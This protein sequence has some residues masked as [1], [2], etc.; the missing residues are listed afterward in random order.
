MEPYEMEKIQEIYG[1]NSELP[2]PINSPIIPPHLIKSNF[3]P[4]KS[5]QLKEKIIQNNATILSRLFDYQKNFHHQAK[6]LLGMTNFTQ[7]MSGHPLHSKNTSISYESEI[8]K[9]RKENMRLK[10]KIEKL[11]NSNK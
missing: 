1:L 5:R 10:H 9:L 3:S 4:T 8:Q 7:F 11:Q 2:N 6:N